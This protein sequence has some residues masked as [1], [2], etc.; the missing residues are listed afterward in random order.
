MLN[1]CR[2]QLV[3]SPTACCKD[4]GERVSSLTTLWSRPKLSRPIWYSALETRKFG[5]FSNDHCMALDVYTIYESYK[6]RRTDNNDNCKCRFGP[7]VASEAISEYL[8]RKNFP[9][10]HTPRHPYM[11]VLI[12]V[13][14]QIVGAPNLKPLPLPLQNICVMLFRPVMS[15]MFHVSCM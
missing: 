4:P 9:G 15:C 5:L 2:S 1:H 10:K 13:Y 6:R 11:C 14:A 8:I 12:H 3:T 7:K